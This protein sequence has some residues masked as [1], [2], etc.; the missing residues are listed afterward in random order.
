MEDLGCGLVFRRR[1]RGA[2][3]TTAPYNAMRGRRSS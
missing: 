3:L 2:E 1:L